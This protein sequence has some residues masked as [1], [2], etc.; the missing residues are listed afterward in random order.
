MKNLKNL[1]IVNEFRFTIFCICVTIIVS[2]I[3]WLQTNKST[4]ERLEFQNKV[5]EDL[6][7][8]QVLSNEEQEALERFNKEME[9]R[10]R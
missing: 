4:K 9:V 10:M 3:G 6:L 5:R 8:V 2:C 7:N 1:K